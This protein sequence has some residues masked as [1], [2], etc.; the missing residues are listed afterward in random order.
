MQ[1]FTLSFVSVLLT[2]SLVSATLKIAIDGTPVVNVPH[3][4]TWTRDGDDASH[5]ILST[6]LLGSGID[7]NGDLSPDTTSDIRTAT[8]GFQGQAQ[9]T[10]H[11]PGL[12][13]V[14]ALVGATNETAAQTSN[15]VVDSTTPTTSTFVFLTTVTPGVQTITFGADQSATTARKKSGVIQRLRS[16]ETFA[17]MTSAII[18]RIIL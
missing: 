16:A 14:S 3:T 4:I 7:S 17:F 8:E 9:L 2:S 12:H 1:P 13:V 18:I 5:F 10:F 11:V 6:T 15:F